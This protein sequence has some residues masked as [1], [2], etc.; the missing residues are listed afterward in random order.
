MECEFAGGI[1]VKYRIYGNKGPFVFVVHG[2]GGAPGDWRGIVDYLQA[3]YR[4]VV[5]AIKNFFTYSK[6]TTYTEHV[7][8]LC[9]F[10]D[11]VMKSVKEQFHLAGSSYGGTL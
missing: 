2:F 1:E 11:C 4:V 7:A 5:P 10:I 3:D 9:E 6:P 8:A